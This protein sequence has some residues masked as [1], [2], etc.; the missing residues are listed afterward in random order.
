MALSS[1][2]RPFSLFLMSDGYVTGYTQRRILQPLSRFSVLI[3]KALD[4]TIIY[5]KNNQNGVT[6]QAQE[7]G[8]ALARLPIV[9]NCKQT[10]T[11]PPEARFP[12]SAIYTQQKFMINISN[13]G[14]AAFC[15]A[16]SF[17][18]HPCSTPTTQQG[19]G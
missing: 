16:I 8:S 18:P 3:L 17:R 11:A 19:E 5:L 1:G 15:T 12:S 7:L 2:T 14:I 6:Y 4:F 10:P 9:P 13:A